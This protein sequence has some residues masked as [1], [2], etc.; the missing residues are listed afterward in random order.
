MPVDIQASFSKAEKLR[1]GLEAIIADLLA[2]PNERRYITAEVVCATT[3][4][5]HLNGDART[6]V[7]KLVGIEPMLTGDDI[8][9][10]KGLYERAFKARTGNMPQEPL[11]LDGDQPQ[12]PLD[13]GD[14]DPAAGP[15]YPSP[16]KEPD[17]Q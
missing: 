13:E 17:P 1:N 15:Y 12:L 3:K 9:D 4:I 2:R 16:F 5:D 7:I 14:A 10:A 6:P 11:P 8:A